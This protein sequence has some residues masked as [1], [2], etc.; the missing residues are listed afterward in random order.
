MITISHSAK[1][2]PSLPYEKIKSR[3]L[4][5]RYELSLVFIGARRAQDL[6]MVYRNATYTPNILSFPLSK[7]IGEIYI[8]PTVARKQAKRWNMTYTGY[9]GL[10]FIHGLLHL[11]GYR[12]GATMEKAEH[13]FVSE[14]GLM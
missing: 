13:L 10:L 3:I 6:N 14:F 4:G 2:F 1:S 12:H 9:V 7:K 11:K 5:E 8:T